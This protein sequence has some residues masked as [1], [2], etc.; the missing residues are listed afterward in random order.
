MKAHFSPSR[1]K[2]ILFLNKPLEVISDV[3]TQSTNK[4]QRKNYGKQ[5]IYINKSKNRAIVLRE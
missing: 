3:N 5:R 2:T 4:K 1:L